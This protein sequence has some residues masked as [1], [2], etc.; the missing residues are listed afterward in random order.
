TSMSQYQ[1][2]RENIIYHP[3]EQGVYQRIFVVSAYAG[4]TDLLLNHKKTGKP[5]VFELY[6][7][8]ISS[9]SWQEKLAQVKQAMFAVNAELFSDK[10]ALQEADQFIAERLDDAESC[11]QDLQRLCL[12]GHFSLESH[13]NSVKEMLA[14]LG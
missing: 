6:S 8:S 9:D 2:V 3:R 4:M 13:L 1:A 11:L 12:H 7:N 5:G 10:Q 14:C